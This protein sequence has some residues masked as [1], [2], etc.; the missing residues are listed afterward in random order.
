ML[1]EV[2]HLAWGHRASVQWSQGLNPG[3]WASNP[4]YHTAALWESLH[5]KS[6]PGQDVP[7]QEWQHSD[8]HLHI[9]GTGCELEMNP[10]KVNHS[11]D[12]RVIT[13]Q[14]LQEASNRP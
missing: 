13:K 3:A 14:E 7:L 8:N 11:W 1:R 9:R 4:S 5:T 6:S 10:Y 2:K 12:H